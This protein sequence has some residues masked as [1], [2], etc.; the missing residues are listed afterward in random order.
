MLLIIGLCILTSACGCLGTSVGDT[1]V[2]DAFDTSNPLVL[3]ELLEESLPEAQRHL[4]ALPKMLDFGDQTLGSPQTRIVTLMNNN[5]NRSVF[6][7]AIVTTADADAS[8]FFTS[9][10]EKVIP[11][12][13]NITFSVIFLPKRHGT[14]ATD[15][16]IHT[17]FGLLKYPVRGRGIECPYRLVPLVGIKAPFN[18]TI[19]P[20]IHLFNP[21]DRPIQIVE[22]FSSG[23]HFQLELP[24]G[25]NEGPQVLWEIPP[26]CSKP[27]IRV[28]FVGVT[29]GNYTAY[30]RIKITGQDA[31]LAEKVLV[32][33]I[34]VEISRERGIYSP[35]SF[36]NL[37]L[38]G[39]TDRVSVF[40]V[41]LTHSGSEKVSRVKVSL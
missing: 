16:L 8:V 5:S 41:N 36:L 2:P 24:S 34:E 39:S 7:D 14:V 35:I 11:P 12:H 33:P 30:V 21:H 28:R 32:V 6:L 22:I 29:P 17:T 25:G 3:E 27:I 18:A 37:G 13:S 15:L 26:L 19:S 10:A 38:H 40:R 20:E 23:G 9:F 4:V 1:N 31:Q